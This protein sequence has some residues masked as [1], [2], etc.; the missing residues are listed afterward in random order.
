MGLSLR[1]L[2]L[3]V[4][5]LVLALMGLIGAKV[6]PLLNPAL[7]ERASLTDCDLRAGACETHFDGGV[8]VQLD[9]QP[10]G[11]P[12]VRPL[13]VTVAIQGLNDAPISVAL[14]FSGVDMNMGYNRVLLEPI[15]SFLAERGALENGAAEPEW[16]N[17]GL[18]SSGSAAPERF[19]ADQEVM[20]PSGRDVRDPATPTNAPHQRYFGEAMLPVCVRDRMTWEALVLVE[21]AEGLLGAPFRFETLR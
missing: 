18:A 16:V 3:L 12:T 4:G 8:S 17:S 20:N 5:V 15:T 21:T 7:V 6:A 14:D 10:R 19:G 11:I 2:W 1:V 9:I 13:V